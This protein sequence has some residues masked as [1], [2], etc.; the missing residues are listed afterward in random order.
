MAKVIFGGGGCR[1]WWGCLVGAGV[2]EEVGDGVGGGVGEG[3]VDGDL[4]EV[5]VV[6]GGDIEGVQELFDEPVRGAGE[7][8]AQEWEFVQEGGVVVL[9]GG[10]L[11]GG[12][13]GFEAGPFGEQV[14]EPGADPLAEGLGGAVAGVGGCFQ[15]ADQRCL[16]GVDLG[17][18]A[19]ERGG[20]GGALAGLLGGAFGQGGGEHG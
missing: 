9:G 2:G 8:I 3:G 14:G 19:A 15:F 1:R 7:N 12:E 4:V 6:D 10:G 18:L 16:G 5:V 20:F 13:F 17:E 11:Q